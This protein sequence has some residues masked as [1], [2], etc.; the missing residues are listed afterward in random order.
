MKS[1]NK[2]YSIFIVIALLFWN[3]LSYYLFYSSTP[4]YSTSYFH[5]LFWIVFLSGIVSILLIQKNVLSNLLKNTILTL[6]LLGILFSSFVVMDR[7]I[8]LIINNDRHTTQMSKG[9]IF[10]PNSSARYK[11]VEFDFTAHINSVGLR[12][13]EI[14]INKNDQFRILC[15]GD[16][17]TYG[18]GVNN[19]T[20]WPA[21]LEEYLS[22]A[23]FDNIEVINCGQP[24][25]YTSPLTNY[26]ENIVPLLKPDLVLLG[27]LQLDDL[28]QIYS[29]KF[30]TGQVF[31]KTEIF[32][33]YIGK[34][35]KIIMR[36]VKSSFVNTL[37]SSKTVDISSYWKRQNNKMF[38]SFK[39][40]QNIR[41][42]T[43]NDT[44][45]TMIESGD[46]KPGLL[47][48]YI[49]FPD[50]ITIFND[51]NHPATKYS[52]NIMMEDVKKMRD[53]CYQNDT[54]LIF[55]NIPMNYFTGHQV[56]R[57]PSDVLNTY[58]LENNNIDKIYESVAEENDIPYL[59]LTD[60]FISL[61]NKSNYLFKYDG[62]P[63]ENGYNE[64]AQ[65]VGDQLI[66][67]NLLSNHGQQ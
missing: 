63:N 18:W 27:V 58:F 44:I 60:H 21:K 61:E 4:I 66:A 12:G 22:S 17:W 26:V 5:I 10:E 20:T 37:S 54:G 51:P 65:Y 23:G 50:R 53:I 39:H 38:D 32:S 14:S 48:Y 2:F 7:A 25:L 16:S 9:L 29:N 57:N 19:Q 3:P 31:S 45:R 55:I 1:E 43:L 24:G 34:F 67:M 59:Q 8:G 28:A 11:T 62:H 41:Y 56:I 13:D 46:L 33:I 35:S 36:F 47:D 52:I 42:Y 64:I 40:W 30:S 6:T 15:F 49:N